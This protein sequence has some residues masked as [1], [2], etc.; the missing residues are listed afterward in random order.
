MKTTKSSATESHPT[1]HAT[2]SAQA[3]R[4][5]A[6]WPRI[7]E[8]SRIYFDAEGRFDG[9]AHQPGT[10]RQYD[11]RVVV[12]LA[13]ALL[14][15]DAADRALAEKALRANDL[16]ILNCAFNM[17]YAM[18]LWHTSA[19]RL[20]PET[21]AWFLEEIRQGTI[22]SVDGALL[23]GAGA[24]GADVSHRGHNLRGIQWHGYNDNHV[25]M[26]TSG[27]I[28]A[29]EL[30]GHEGEIEAGRASLRQMRELLHRRGFISECNDCYLPHTMYPLASIVAWAKDE[31]CRALAQD[32]LIRI[33]SDLLGHWHPNLGR[34]LGPSARDYTQGRLSSTGWLTLLGY[35][36]G[37]AALPAWLNLD[38]ILEP[39][40]TPPERR[41][42]WPHGGGSSWTL[43]FLVRVSAQPFEVPDFLASHLSDKPYPCEIVGTNEFGNMLEIWE[44]V[45]P[46]TRVKTQHGLGNIQY[47]GGPHLLTSYMEEDWGMGTADQRL[48]GMCP[49]N[50][51]QVSYRKA[52]PLADIRQQGSWYCSY[53]INDKCMSEENHLEMIE[54]R[55]E[56]ATA[57]GPVHFADA[58]RF[59]G[60]Q[61]RRTS[62]LVYRPR[63][64][65]NWKLTSLGLTLLYPRHY[66]NQVD[67]LWLGDQR[68]ENW[69]GASP[70]ITD[71]FVKDGPV[72]LGFRPLISPWHEDLDGPAS[73]GVPHIKVEQRGLWGCIQL[74]SYSGPA[75]AI[76]Q[77]CD[78]A[79][80]GSGFL[81]EVATESD[82][83][84][85][86]AFKAW[87]RAGRI[88]DDTFHWQRQ[89]RY[90]RDAAHGQPPLDLGLRW[91][92]WQDRIISRTLD[93][94]P[95]PEP[96]FACTGMDNR[97]LPWLT[98]EPVGSDATQWLPT[99]VNR[100]QHKHGHQP[101]SVQIS[102]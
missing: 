6:L 91:D 99:L 52:R 45:H 64:L 57:H 53:T 26:G 87:F 44:E 98:G 33:W 48:L 69:T 23:K 49:N 83:P 89:I 24:C 51:W 38:D 20:T 86:A 72:Y 58:G 73:L 22:T 32:G 77:E 55:P 76:R 60:I 11:Q 63:P 93:G 94:R 66:G 25:A 35:V 92:A 70:V 68:I 9:N 100:P 79:R 27:L 46:E 50:N 90:H 47:A 1:L 71:I 39:E 43:G 8:K 59:A 3:A 10:E 41:L 31:E 4:R 62:I 30:T 75:L 101:L 56:S 16:M 67:E 17:D 80:L 96:Q 95:L 13:I 81:V 12:E 28:L 84:N 36:F 19:D 34:K 14:H 74:L 18:A 61:H 29:G 102:K 7:R 21:R 54:G 88:V 82:F 37:P 97:E 85:L 78:L 42:E 15:G 2:A 40:L 65:E 5:E